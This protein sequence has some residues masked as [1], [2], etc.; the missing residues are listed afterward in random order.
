MII[1]GIEKGYCKGNIEAFRQ[2]CLVLF[3]WAGHRLK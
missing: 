1:T 3:S 2:K